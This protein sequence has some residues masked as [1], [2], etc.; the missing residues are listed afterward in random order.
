MPPVKDGD[1]NRI[2]HL[3]E[4]YINENDVMIFSKSWCPYCKKIKQALTSANIDFYSIEL[5]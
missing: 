5:D 3:V 4:K 1:E 2:A